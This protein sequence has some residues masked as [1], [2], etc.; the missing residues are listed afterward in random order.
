MIRFLKILHLASG[1]YAM[2]LD[3]NWTQSWKAAKEFYDDSECAYLAACR[4]YEFW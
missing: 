2:R 1:I 3:K 4:R